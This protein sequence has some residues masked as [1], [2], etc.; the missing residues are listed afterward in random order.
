MTFD[1]VLG[2]L[3]KELDRQEPCHLPLS[4]KRSLVMDLLWAVPTLIVV[5]GLEAISDTQGLMEE[6]WHLASRTSVKVLITSRSRFTEFHDIKHFE[7][8]GLVESDAIQLLRTY[9]SERSIEAVDKVS[10][11]D[12]NTL[13][14]ASCGNPLVIRWMVNQ[15]AVLPLQQVLS[16]L[17]HRTGSGR[18]IYDFIYGSAWELLSVPAR[19]VLVTIARSAVSGT[20]WKPLRRNTGLTPE[21]LNRSLQELVAASFVTV[22][23]NPDPYYQVTPMTCA[24]VLAESDTAKAGQKPGIR[25]FHDTFDDQSAVS[26]PVGSLMMIPTAVRAKSTGNEKA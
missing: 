5:D 18:E 12:L 15:L 20:A 1:Q 21:M 17:S 14:N 10:P 3:H 24:F 13:A 6:L 16:A 4:E 9:A 11:E 2:F 8:R 26:L 7:M 22:S 19:Q 23:A 25:A